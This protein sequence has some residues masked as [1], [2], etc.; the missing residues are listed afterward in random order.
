MKLLRAASLALM[1][2][3]TAA[4][5]YAQQ[6]TSPAPVESLATAQ[7][8]A[9]GAAAAKASAANQHKAEPVE[10]AARMREHLTYLFQYSMT[11]P[12]KERKPYNDLLFSGGLAIHKMENGAVA[13]EVLEGKIKELE[14]FYEDDRKL[15]PKEAQSWGASMKPITGPQRRY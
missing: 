13:P 8:N 4:G 3:F 1:V 12:E 10:V 7:K 15:S 14:K 9:E 11:L 5:A 6:A 2:S